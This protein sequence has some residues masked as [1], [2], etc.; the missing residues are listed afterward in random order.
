VELLGSDDHPISGFTRKDC[1][2]LVGDHHSI[3]VKWSGGDQAPPGAKKAKFYLKRV[4]L[5][6]F[7]FQ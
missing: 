5:Y 2:P 7:E 6:G 4:F 1:K 3:E